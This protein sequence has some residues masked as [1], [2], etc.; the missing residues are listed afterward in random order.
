MSEDCERKFFQ[1]KHNLITKYYNNNNKTTKKAKEN[2]I[3][4]SLRI[5]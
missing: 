5:P 1:L 3:S 2:I 4:S